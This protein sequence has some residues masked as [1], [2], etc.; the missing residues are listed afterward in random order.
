MFV[1]FKKAHAVF[2]KIVRGNVSVILSG[3]KDFGQSANVVLGV[4]SHTGFAG[5]VIVKG[6]T[7]FCFNL[8]GLDEVFA[9]FDVHWIRLFRFCLTL[10]NLADSFRDVNTF[11]QLF[12]HP[13]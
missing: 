4:N 3:C 6:I 10:F 8:A 13:C 12:L 11:F 1:A 7:N 2:V 5:N 9:E